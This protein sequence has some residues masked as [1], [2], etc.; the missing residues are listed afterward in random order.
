MDT[1]S[2]GQSF[3]EVNL[4]YGIPS[5]VTIRSSTF[6]EVIVIDAT[7]F[8]TILPSSKVFGEMWSMLKSS[9]EFLVVCASLI[10]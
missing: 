6:I 7:A 10:P 9:P 1:L 2:T 5:R 8:E 4:L 3:G